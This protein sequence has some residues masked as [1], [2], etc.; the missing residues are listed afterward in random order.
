M[1]QSSKE[2]RATEFGNMIYQKLA[3]MFP[4]LNF[5]DSSESNGKMGYPLPHYN[6]SM[7]AKTK[8]EGGGFGKKKKFN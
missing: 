1:I 3:L 6:N 4:I 5:P 8:R 7:L 2:I